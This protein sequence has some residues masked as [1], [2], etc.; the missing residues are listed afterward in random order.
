MLKEYR[1]NGPIVSQ[2]NKQC[3][4]YIHPYQLALYGEAGS[5]LFFVKNLARDILLMQVDKGEQHANG[6]C[7]SFNFY[8][9]QIMITTVK[10]AI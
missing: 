10:H 9:L 8:F 6:V 5:Y 2:V 7:D 4:C 3:K 1:E